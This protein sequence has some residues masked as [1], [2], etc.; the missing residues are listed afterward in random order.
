MGFAAL[1]PSYGTETVE[2]TSPALAS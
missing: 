2:T 1:N